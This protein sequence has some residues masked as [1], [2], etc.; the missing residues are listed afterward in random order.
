MQEMVELSKSNAI[1]KTQLQ[2]VSFQRSGEELQVLKA[3]PSHFG[4]ELTGDMSISQRAVF[5]S[6]SKVCTSEYHYCVLRDIVT[7]NTLQTN[8]LNRL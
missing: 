1:P 6:P 5:A 4:P 3:G 8:I 7:F 2:E